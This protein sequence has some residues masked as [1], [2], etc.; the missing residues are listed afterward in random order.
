M[1]VSLLDAWNCGEVVVSMVFKGDGVEPS[2][3]TV[4]HELK[5]GGSARETK[6]L[7]HPWLA[8]QAI[9]RYHRHHTG[10]SV[11]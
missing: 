1:E 3:S 6:S 2:S 10:I 4:T 11:W 8:G 9:V 5:S 7:L